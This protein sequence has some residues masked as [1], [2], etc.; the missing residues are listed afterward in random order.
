MVVMLRTLRTCP[1]PLPI[2]ETYVTV[3]MVTD[4]RC[5]GQ[6]ISHVRD[7]GGPM[8]DVRSGDHRG[9]RFEIAVL[10]FLQLWSVEF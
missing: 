4:V 6:G 10:L 9:P 3:V 7:V 1:Y 8:Y 5:Q 2:E